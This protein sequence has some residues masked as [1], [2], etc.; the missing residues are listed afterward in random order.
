[1][2]GFST[3]CTK[4]PSTCPDTG[5]RHFARAPLAR[6]LRLDDYI[7]WTLHENGGGDLAT[8]RRR[9]TIEKIRR[10]GG[11]EELEEMDSWNVQDFVFRVRDADRN[12]R[13]ELRTCNG[14]VRLAPRPDKGY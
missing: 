3:S 10:C 8:T 7:E 9:G 5:F 11:H 12:R 4:T 6:R 13:I 1:M 14:A 2:T